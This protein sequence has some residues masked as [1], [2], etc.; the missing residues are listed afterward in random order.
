MVHIR[1]YRA[2]TDKAAVYRIFADGMNGLPRNGVIS[3][4]SAVCPFVGALCALWSAGAFMIGCSV[5]VVLSTNI[6][7]VAGA[8]FYIYHH[9]KQGFR[10]Y[11][12]GSLQDDLES[13]DTFY[14]NNG[15]SHFWVAAEEAT[16]QV[17]GCVA[18]DVHQDA[19]GWG[20]LRRMSVDKAARRRGVAAKLHAALLE[21]A[22][23]HKLQGIFLTTSNIQLAAIRLYKKLGYRHEK[24]EA[25]GAKVTWM[26]PLV[27]TLMNK[28]LRIFTF[29]LKL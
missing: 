7:A 25:S 9:L 11:V 8:M 22:K 2:S 20:Q 24:T 3:V 28:G 14:L 16:D 23:Q 17:I 10:L 1:S 21:H 13:I 29:R 18:L 6:L 5:L 27:R 12:E 26:P 19:D 15:A 4:T